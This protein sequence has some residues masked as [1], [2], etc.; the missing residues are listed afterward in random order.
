MVRELESP[1]KRPHSRMPQEDLIFRLNGI[2]RVECGMHKGM[3]HRHA[4]SYIWIA[5]VEGEGT[6][7]DESGEAVL[8]SGGLRLVAPKRTFGIEAGGERGFGAFLISFDIFRE[9]QDEPGRLRAVSEETAMSGGE[10]DEI[11]L[12]GGRLEALC[13]SIWR[14]WKNSASAERLKARAEF[15]ELVGEWAAVSASP[16]YDSHRL[17]QRTKSFIDEHYREPLK[18]DRLAGMAGLSRSYYAD[19]FKKRYGKSVVEYMTDLRIRRAK[20]LMANSGLKLREVAQQVGYGDEFYFSRRFK[21]E[22]GVAPSAYI[23]SRSRRIAAYCASS[24]G[25]LLALGIVPYAAPLHLKWTSYYY[26]RYAADIPVHLNG[27]K[28]DADRQ[29][30]LDRLE[31]SR[32]ERIVCG[33]DVSAEEKERLERIADVFYIRPE[34]DWR[35][36][37]RETAAALGEREEAER[38]LESYAEAAATIGASI[39]SRHPDERTLLLRFRSGDFYSAAASSAAGVLRDDLGIRLIGPPAKDG[40]EQALSL[41]ALEADRADRILLLVCQEGETLPG[42]EAVRRSP[43]W[44]ELP[45]VR[46]GRLHLLPSDPWRECSPSAHKRVLLEAARIF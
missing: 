28:L 5:A 19:Q 42:W 29:G 16:V 23:K 21:Q 8:R 15:L 33:A 30:N 4:S 11:Y 44:A 41:A 43:E 27:Y 24:A 39:G 17:M 14:R 10:A 26:N 31:Q 46:S 9:E 38:W 25:Y 35:T 13:E 18:I 36:A 6:I 12:P 7:S 1:Q 2:E 45:A 37:L 3:P 32:P 20:R 40:E 22:T 34:A